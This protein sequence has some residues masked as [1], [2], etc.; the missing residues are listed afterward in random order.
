MT[1]QEY[2]A[3]A[4]EKIK[5]L[6]Y[7]VYGFNEPT[8]NYAFF[9]D[10]KNIGYFQLDDFIGFAF[11]TVHK[12]C[13]EAGTGYRVA[14]EITLDNITKELCEKCFVTIPHGFIPATIHKYYDWNE[15]NRK[16]RLT[17]IK[18]KENDVYFPE[19]L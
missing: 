3:Q 15:F 11:S 8:T 16:R 18:D 1:R 7:K 10:E 6:G 2:F 9:T 17:S 5:S 14:D 12:P 13:R 4:I 19:E